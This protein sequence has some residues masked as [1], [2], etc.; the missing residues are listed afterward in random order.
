MARG[1]DEQCLAISEATDKQGYIMARDSIA[2]QVR[3]D[4]DED[5][6]S[7]QGSRP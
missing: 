4:T 7:S 1:T 6:A 2:S 5:G 3:G